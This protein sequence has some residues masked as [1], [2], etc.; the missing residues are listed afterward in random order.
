MFHLNVKHSLISTK[1]FKS[2]TLASFLLFNN[3][4]RMV[5][6]TLKGEPPAPF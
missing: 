6:E 3:G 1:K 2:E 5:R 4:L